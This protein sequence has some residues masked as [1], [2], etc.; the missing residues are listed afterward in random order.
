MSNLE[1][2]YTKAQRLIC[3]YQDMQ[4]IVHEGTE[5]RIVKAWN[6]RD[7]EYQVGEGDSMKFFYDL[8]EVMEYVSNLND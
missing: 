1:A 8:D 5:I 6:N 2:L 7:L 3:E 4:S